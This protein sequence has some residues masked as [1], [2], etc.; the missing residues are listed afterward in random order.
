MIV[1]LLFLVPTTIRF[2]GTVARGE[3]KPSVNA[4]KI[5]WIDMRR[6]EEH[7]KFTCWHTNCFGHNLLGYFPLPFSSYTPLLFH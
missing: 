4:W 7:Y 2:L 3:G 5:S 6:E 1:F